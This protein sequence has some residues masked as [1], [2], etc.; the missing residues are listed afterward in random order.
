MIKRITAKT[1]AILIVAAVMFTALPIFGVSAVSYS[2]KGTKSNPYLVETAEQLMGISN[3][4]SACY[5][6]NNTIDLSGVSFEPIGCLATPFTGNFTCDLDSDGTPKYAIKNFSYKAITY[7]SLAQQNASFKSD[8]TNKWEAGLFRSTKGAKITNILLID[9]KM[10]G[11][12]IGESKMNADWS[13]NKGMGHD[14]GLGLMVGIAESTDFEGC[15][16]TGTMDTNDISALF[17]GTLLGCNVSKCYV[18]GSVK[19]TSKWCVAGFAGCIE[20]SSTIKNCFAEADVEAPNNMAPCAFGNFA[21][22]SIAENC[23]FSGN[24]AAGTKFEGCSEEATG[25]EI[26]NCK[27]SPFD[28]GIKKITDFSK[29]VPSAQTSAP[30]G[31]SGANSTQGDETQ[32]ETSGQEQLDGTQQESKT[33]LT[34]EEF[35]EKLLKLQES[36][37][38]GWSL[39]EALEVVELKTAYSE[40]TAEEAAKVLPSDLEVMTKLYDSAKVIVVRDMTESIDKLPS[41]DKVTAKNAA[42]VLEVCKKFNSLPQEIQ[43][44]FNSKRVTKVKECYEKAKAFEGVQ[45]VDTKLKASST[46]TEKALIILLAAVNVLLLATAV[47]F[48]VLVFKKLRE[49]NSDAETELET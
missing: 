14:N 32:T 49:K 13:L 40:M 7:S 36:Q 45:I 2:G 37:L 31:E 23:Y 25:V 44:M 20:Q 41:P 17:A 35:A 30:Q 3:N 12:V 9:A 38:K 39:D 5:K 18:V 33:K 10:T 42:K 24:V 8:K 11:G 43:E 47:T 29:Y 1:A 6:L 15:I 26:R 16:V 46:A 21:K 22:K 48:A 27:M 28:V 19:S 4:L 34:A